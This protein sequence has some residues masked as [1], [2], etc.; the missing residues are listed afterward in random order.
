[1]IIV[2][3]GAGFIGS[4]VVSYLNQKGIKDIVIVDNLG[5]TEK[6]KNLVGKRYLKYVHKDDFFDAMDDV[7]ELEI[8]EAIIHLG[9]CSSTTELDADY[10]YSN[11]TDFSMRIAEWAD[12]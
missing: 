6:W 11:N 2:T 8:P 3:G 12:Y 4:A 10:L 5:K 1:M 9:A 7:F